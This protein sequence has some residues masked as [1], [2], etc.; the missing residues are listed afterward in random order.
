VGA[1]RDQRDA[2]DAGSGRV[3]D[4]RGRDAGTLDPKVTGCLPT[5]TGDATRAAQVFLEGSK[6][7]VSVLELH[8]SP[9]ADFRDVVAEFEAE[10]YQKP[11]RKRGDP[12][13]PNPYDLR[14]RRAGG[15]RPTGAPPDPV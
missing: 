5:L 11:P 9:P 10:I 12:P 2:G 7:Y 4:P 1:R 8:G 14:S 6:E 15:R 3:P 13:A